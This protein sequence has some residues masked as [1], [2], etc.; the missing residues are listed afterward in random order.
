MEPITLISLM[1]LIVVVVGGLLLVM[2]GRVIHVERQLSEERV[3]SARQYI[4]M[5]ELERRL[6]L[7][8]AP[9][10]RTLE[11][12]EQQNNSIYEMLNVNRGCQ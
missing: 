11:R 6:E 8:V 10:E 5:G 7:A 9:I 3:N 4:T 1:S 2:W 12:L